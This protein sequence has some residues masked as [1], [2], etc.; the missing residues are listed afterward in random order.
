MARKTRRTGAKSASSQSASKP[1]PK[2]NGDGTRDNS[3][4]TRQATD[5]ERKPGASIEVGKA[6]GGPLS[7]DDA[8]AAI[9]GDDPAPVK[10]TPSDAPAKDDD[11]PDA[12]ALTKAERYAAAA[13]EREK[14][15]PPKKTATKKPGIK[16]TKY[17]AW[18]PSAVARSRHLSGMKPGQPGDETLAYPGPKQHLAVR[19]VVTE[20][21]AKGTVLKDG[22]LVVPDNAEPREVTPENIVSLTGVKS[23][24]AL[25]KIATWEADRSALV[26]MR[27]LSNVCGAASGVNGKTDGWAIGRYLA[28]ALVAWVDEIRSEAK[29]AK[30][31]EKAAAKD[32]AKEDGAAVAA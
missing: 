29:A 30:D 8:L 27:A 19:R 17:P 4:R 13:A 22:A 3:V 6:T 12:P 28:A 7:G 31:A 21:L 32:A 18:M 26:P 9:R 24:P 10:D 20:A 11:A 5:E 23:V 25:T 15:A 1:A 16:A 2:G 14:N